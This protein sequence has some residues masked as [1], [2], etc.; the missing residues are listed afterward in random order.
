MTPSYGPMV[1]SS[2]SLCY[3]HCWFVRNVSACMHTHTQMNASNYHFSRLT[4]GGASVQCERVIANG[5]VKE[6]SVFKLH[7]HTAFV[8]ACSW[9]HSDCQPITGLEKS[10]PK[11]NGAMY[12][13]NRSAV[14]S[15]VWFQ[16]PMSLLSFTLDVL[17]VAS[18]PRSVRSV[19]GVG[20][21]FSLLGTLLA[22]RAEER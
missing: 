5:P 9:L 18:L 6:M 14:L 15:E 7:A 21:C 22:R 8:C 16:F 13:S 3:S 2:G 17:C 12:T 20:S 10:E 19:F 11:K 4:R 1:I